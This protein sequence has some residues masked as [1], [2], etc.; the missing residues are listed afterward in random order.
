VQFPAYLAFTDPITLYRILKANKGFDA[1]YTTRVVILFLTSLLALPFN[2]LERALYGRRIAAKQISDSPLI[3]LGHDRSGTTHLLN[4]MS[5]DPQFAYTRPSQMVLP[6]CCILFDRAFDALLRLLD[7]RRPFDN[8][9]VGPGSPQDDEVPLVKLTPHCEYHKYSFPRNHAYWLDRYVLNFG[10]ESPAYAE[11]KR[12]YLGTLR[13]AAVLMRRDRSLLKSPATMA[14]LNVVLELF[15]NAKFIH[16]KRDPY[17]VIPSQIHLHRTMARKYGLETVT[18][19]QITEFALYQY[20]AYTLA[21][22]RERRRIPSGN[23]IE[24]RHEDFVADRMLW[25]HRI[26]DTLALGEFEP[27]ARR[28]EE[29]IRT[30]EHYEP[31]RYAED[32]ALKRRIDAELG[33]AV[34]ALGYAAGR[35]DDRCTLRSQPH[36]VTHTKPKR[37][38]IGH[39]VDQDAINRA[40]LSAHGCPRNHPWAQHRRY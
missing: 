35:A 14:N 37:G 6:G 18:E 28:F 3:I 29:Y 10:V 12:T 22:M 15:P 27:I 24:V 20:R 13:K 31:N 7:Y 23:M 34:T 16:I 32:P 25:L 1:R 8:M 33:F 30:V 39:E 21:F 4:L 2:W 19:E 38:G 36:H 5:I 40:S 26:Y 9:A 11:W 17:R